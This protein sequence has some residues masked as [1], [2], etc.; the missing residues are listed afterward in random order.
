M[1]GDWNSCA[2]APVP[3]QSAPAAEER[4]CSVLFILYLHRTVSLT[5]AGALVVTYSST[6]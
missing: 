5:Q 1:F 4:V 6:L 3:S 2:Q